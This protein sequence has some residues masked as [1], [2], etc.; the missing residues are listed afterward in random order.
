MQINRDLS[1]KTDKDQPSN[2]ASTKEDI[3]TQKLLF[4]STIMQLRMEKDGLEKKVK[5]ISSELEQLQELAVQRL[6]HIEQLK[7]EN[8]TMCLSHNDEQAAL[9]NRF[10]GHVQN[11]YD[12]QEITQKHKSQVR[13]LENK[14]TMLEEENNRLKDRCYELEGAQNEKTYLLK[15]LEKEHTP[16]SNMEKE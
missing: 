16:K 15:V 7:I 12:I 5:S 3:E 14:I 9:R 1:A 2:S 4:E 6:N 11:Y 10:E 8:K 13:A